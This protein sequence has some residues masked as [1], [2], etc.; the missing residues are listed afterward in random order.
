MKQQTRPRAESTLLR[1]T[2]GT[3]GDDFR[4]SPLY[5]LRPLQAPAFLLPKEYYPLD[6][7]VTEAAG[8]ARNSEATDLYAGSY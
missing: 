2:P 3:D 1:V 7:T 5:P 4:F 8:L 6:D